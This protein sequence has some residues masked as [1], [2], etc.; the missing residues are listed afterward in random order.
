VAAVKA[1]AAAKEERL[2]AETSEKSAEEKNAFF[3]NISHD[4][5]TPLN[6]ITGFIRMA[7][8]DGISEKERNEYL[9][10][11]DQSGELLLNLVDDTLTMSKAGSGKLQLY[12]EPVNNIELLESILVPVRET[13]A[14]RNTS[15]SVD[16]SRIRERVIMADRLNMQKIFLNLL[17]NAV[18]YTPE[19]GHVSFEAYFDPEEGASPDTV[20]KISDN[21][22][23]ISPE[24]MPRLFK[25]FTQEKR[26]GY[27]AVG[28]GL[29]LSIVKQL[30]DL[31]DGSIDVQS[32]KDHGTTFTVRLHFDETETK[33]EISRQPGRG[34]V[35]SGRKV[36]LCE[37]NELNREIAISLLNDKGISVEP[38]EDG[39]EGV[40]KFS[41][42]AAGEFD[43]VL[44]DVR[45]PVMDG[46]EATREIRSMKRADAKTVPIIAMTAD[47]F[48]EDMQK[49]LDAGM[50][51]YIAKPID[52]GKMY[53][54][55][56]LALAPQKT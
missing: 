51:G 1:E 8:K 53:Q 50:N 38:A 27:A 35:L 33:K 3:A 31:M 30:I 14:R 18:K 25:P 52:P 10:K 54:A 45:M 28:T 24:F 2:K 22:I 49:C 44:M 5:R 12:P 7:R 23:G 37:D 19:G 47:A 4:M 16:Y 21:G 40:K 34:A 15:F 56:S 46:L 6:A 17:S 26:K 48:A 13:A 39:E 20:V 9:K 36:L 11:A 29:G 55:L 41:D 43:A 42:S 32:E